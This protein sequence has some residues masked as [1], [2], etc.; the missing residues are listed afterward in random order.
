MSPHVVNILIIVLVIAVLFGGIGRIPAIARMLGRAM[1]EFKKGVK[2]GEEE[3]E[4][5]EPES[6]EKT[7]EHK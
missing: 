5:K 4:E 3:K 7:E 6:A 1:G 2:E